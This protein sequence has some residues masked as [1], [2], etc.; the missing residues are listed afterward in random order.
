MVLAIRT[1]FI[2]FMSLLTDLSYTTVQ[3]L[4][5]VIIVYIILLIILISLDRNFYQKCLK[6][7]KDIIAKYDD[8]FY[9]LAKKQYKEEIDKQSIWW[10]PCIAAILPVIKSKNKSY[11]YHRFKIKS[12]IQ[13][14]EILLK[15]QV[16]SK[17][18]REDIDDMYRSLKRTKLFHKI[19]SKLLIFLTLG[20]YKLFIEDISKY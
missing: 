16:I 12:N 9:L 18:D 3:V 6:L 15:D 10:D 11:L 19:F 5:V 7:T 2:W 20:I 17:E 13:K 14:V 4:F 1:Q 8:F